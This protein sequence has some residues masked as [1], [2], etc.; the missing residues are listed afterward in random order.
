MAYS[1]MTNPRTWTT[2]ETVTA[3]IMNTH[4][5][6]NQDAMF[7]NGDNWDTWTQSVSNIT[8][9]GTEVSRYTRIG[10]LI[11]CYY[12]IEFDASGGPLSTDVG[13]GL[14]ETPS[15][16]YADDEPIGQLLCRDSSAGTSY[17]GLVVL[18]SSDDRAGFR[19]WNAAST[20]AS[21]TEISNTVPFT[22]D[23]GDDFQWYAIYEA[24]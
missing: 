8:L 13:I 12:K 21:N 9:S 4:I 19:V 10:D 7:P 2:G 14:P 23:T 17:P 22:W 1:N 16:N 6:D 11:F 24:A 15:T 18:R 5:R 3:A 20:Y